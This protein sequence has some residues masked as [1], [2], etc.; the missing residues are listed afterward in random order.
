MFK[1]CT[2]VRGLFARPVSCRG[3]APGPGP[4]GRRRIWPARGR[5]EAA[6][7]AGGAQ[8]ALS[9]AGGIQIAEQ[10]G[11]YGTTYARN[12]TMRWQRPT[13]LRRIAL[14]ARANWLSFLTPTKSRGRP[15][16]VRVFCKRCRAETLHDRFDDSGWGWYAQFWQCRVCGQEAVEVLPI[17]H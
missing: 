1:P 6:D 5:A 12:Q 9:E 10:R 16:Q 17:A 11:P 2:A 13:L 7:W 8:D 4:G 3:R 15:E 14:G